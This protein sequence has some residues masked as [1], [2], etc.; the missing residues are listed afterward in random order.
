MSRQDSGWTLLAVAAVLGGG[1]LIAQQQVVGGHVLD[2]NLAVGSGGIN[3]AVSP[4]TYQPYS[5]AARPQPRTATIG[6]VTGGVS[7]GSSGTSFTSYGYGLS[8]PTYN[9]LK[10]A[11]MVQRSSS[12]SSVQSMY[13]TRSPNGASRPSYGS[14]MGQ[15]VYVPVSGSQ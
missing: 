12:A 6:G 1:P 10:P 8:R 14:T 11:A 3:T 15:P 4:R 5:N 7:R 13:T 9:P 2:N